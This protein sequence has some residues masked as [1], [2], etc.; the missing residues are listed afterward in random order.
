MKRSVNAP[1]NEPEANKFAPPSEGVHSF[2]IIDVN[3]DKNNPDIV[4][5]KMEVCSALDNGRSISN[6]I[7]LDENSKGFFATRLLL[8]AIGEPYKGSID[9]DTDM[10]VGKTLVATIVHNKV[11]K[12]GTI[13]TYAN[14]GEYLF[15]QPV[16][17]AEKTEPAPVAWEE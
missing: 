14:I 15:E 4:F 10:W 9:I 1:E 5:V 7:N 17:V 12:N 16:E 8:K 2:Q 13:K 3:E 6:R 11:E